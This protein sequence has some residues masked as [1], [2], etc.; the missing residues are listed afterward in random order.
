MVLVLDNYDSFTYN[1]VQLLGGMEP[2]VRVCRNDEIGASG[3]AVLVPDHIV[4]SSGPGTPDT[5]GQSLAIV[6]HFA[7]KVPLLGVCLGCQVIAQAYGARIVRAGAVM[8][9][10]TSAVYHNGQGLFK[11][12]KNP[13]TAMR[14]HSLVVEP[15]SVPECLEVT[16]QT[17]DG[18]IMGLR[19]RAGGIEGVQ[20]HPESI[21]T[22]EGEKL[23]RNF[24]ALDRS[25]IGADPDGVPPLSPPHS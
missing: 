5:A 6:R 7:G 11:N 24:F 17:E 25:V 8:H 21:L 15:S 19:H 13:F 1:L 18:V 10:M 23:V 20:F 12:L 16:A 2:N 3:I 4:I 22:Q 14:Y 9:G